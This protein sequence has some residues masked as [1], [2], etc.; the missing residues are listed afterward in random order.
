MSSSGASD[1]RRLRPA[2]VLG[3]TEAAC[4]VFAEGQQSIVPYAPFFPEGRGER[5]SPGHLVAVSDALD[6][7]SPVVVWRWI[8][9]VVV[10]VAGG[11]LTLWEPLHGDV[12]AQ[13]RDPRRT[14]PLGARA[15]VSAGLPGAEWWVAGP[16]V[17]C[18]EDAEVDFEEVEHFLASLT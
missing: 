15:Y 5:V 16:V 6:K 4:S 14:Y 8:D 18:A 7:S 10:D 17:D 2:L 9:A 1:A 13:P 3:T 12:R 11:M